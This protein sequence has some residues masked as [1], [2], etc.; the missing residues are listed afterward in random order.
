[1]LWHTNFAQVRSRSPRRNNS[2]LAFPGAAQLASSPAPT[3]MGSNKKGK[4]KGQEKWEEP[5]SGTAPQQ[6]RAPR[7]R[8]FGSSTR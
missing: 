8:G 3:A 4:G 2:Q 5:D 6:R 7:Q 1:M